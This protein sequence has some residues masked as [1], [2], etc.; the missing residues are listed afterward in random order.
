MLLDFYLWNLQLFSSDVAGADCV[1]TA[2]LA[3]SGYQKGLDYGTDVQNL[4]PNPAPFDIHTLLSRAFQSYAPI[5]SLVPRFD[6]LQNQPPAFMS[7]NGIPITPGAK[8]TELQVH[9]HQ[10]KG[11]SHRRS[12]SRE[13]SS[14]CCSF[15]DA[16]MDLSRAP[17]PQM[18]PGATRKRNVFDVL[19]ALKAKKL[20]MAPTVLI[21]VDFNVP[22]SKD[23]A[24]TD[25][26]RIRGALP[27]I[28][29]VLRA[30]C[31]AVLVSHLGRP[32]LVQK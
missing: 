5:I 10:R 31:N 19:E 21:R 1:N 7:A 11:Y 22:M 25:D 8:A 27:T 26:S 4:D 24:I 16:M 9:N 29:A 15:T 13:A 32:S 3:N 18:A 17:I 20:T 30:K 23:L 2:E 12:F 28:K 14:S 6:V